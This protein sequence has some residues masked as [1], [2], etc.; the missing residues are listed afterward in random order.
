MMIGESILSRFGLL[1]LGILTF[2]TLSCSGSEDVVFVKEDINETTDPD[3][4][5]TGILS[6]KEITIEMSAGFNLGNVFD[7]G[8]NAT[9]FTSIKP[10]IDLYVDAGM[11]HV[12]IPVTWMD[13]FTNNLANENGII[14]INNPRFQELVKTIDY[15][16]S[17]GLYVVINTHHEVWL[18][19]HYDGS[20]VYESKFFTL[21]TEI[22]THFKE[23][24]QHLIFEILNEPEGKLG[25]WSSTENWPDPNSSIALSSTRTVN[26]IG[27]NAIRATGG[28]NDTRFIMVSVNGQGNEVMIEEVYPN[29]SYLPGGG[30]DK[31]LGIQVH[32][33][34]P[35]SFCGQTGNN[36]NFPG[37]ATIENAIKKVGLHSKLLDVPINYGEFGV[38]RQG[39]SSSPIS[40]RNS[41]IVKGY[42]RTFHTRTLS[43]QMSYS[44]WDDR[45]WF[46]LVNQTGTNFTNNIVPFMFTGNI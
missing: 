23:Y 21:W 19:D 15:A 31:Y 45:G 14:D 11:K 27:Y 42:Y 13:R 3:P 35:W 12:R 36:S 7:N 9:T 17:I 29:K 26:E 32:S 4:S 28:K 44:V 22:A 6:A 8:I 38:G 46:G 40:E 30:S 37:T 41:D 5:R 25:Q 34:N 18:K 33:Y 24:D 20:G 16:I 1:V 39:T 43:E 10:I 2:M